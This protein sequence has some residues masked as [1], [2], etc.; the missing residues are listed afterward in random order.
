MANLGGTITL[1]DG[2]GHQITS[3]QTPLAE[4]GLANPLLMTTSV[5]TTTVF[6]TAQNAVGSGS[7]GDLAVSAL[8]EVGIDITTT[9]TSGG[10]IQ[11]FWERKGIDGIYYPLWQSAVLSAAANILSTSVGPGLAFAQ[12]LGLTGRLRWSISAGTWTFTPNVYGK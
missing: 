12:S 2:N 9:A 1:V 11:F 10:T 6:S 8:R 7:S 5:A 3:G 4:N